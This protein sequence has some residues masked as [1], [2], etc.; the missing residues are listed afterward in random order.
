MPQELLP[1][2]N[3][4]GIPG[5]VIVG[6]WFVLKQVDKRNTE[7][8]VI[9]QQILREGQIRIESLVNMVMD[10]SREDAKNRA[11][12]KAAIDSSIESIARMQEF[13]KGQKFNG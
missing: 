12:L 5:L 13:C 6:M 11:E 3:Q 2:I 10:L 9:I 1:I 8:D 7:K 4:F